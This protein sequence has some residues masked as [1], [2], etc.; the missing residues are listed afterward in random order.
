MSAR[1]ERT[2]KK[3]MRTHRRGP[4]ASSQTR[5]SAG[6]NHELLE[7]MDDPKKQQLEIFKKIAGM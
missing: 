5:N 7:Q 3:P 1:D 6:K 2:R 4:F